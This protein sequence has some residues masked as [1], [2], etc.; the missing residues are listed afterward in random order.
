M[1]NRGKIGGLYLILDQQYTNRD[2]VS[3]A[4]EAAEAGVDVIQYREK[5]LPKK[6]ALGVAKRLREVTEEAGVMFIVNDDP[7][8][9]LGAGADG[10]HLGQEDIPV[11]VARRILG[12]N[13]VIGISTHSIEEALEA[14]RLDVDYIGF[15]PVFHSVTKRVTSP[16]GLEGVR[17]IRASVSMPV[18]AIGGIDQGNV[19]AVIR[20]GADGAAVISAVLSAPDVKKAVSELKKGIGSGRNSF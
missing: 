19:S 18:I 13:K 12:R 7:A 6:G 17:R 5:V 14:G 16:H 3:I 10:V 9:A 11:D 4:I 8:L 15:G 1:P 20:A 2:I